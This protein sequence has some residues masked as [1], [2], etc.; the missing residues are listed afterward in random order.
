MKTFRHWLEGRTYRDQG[1][2]VVYHLNSENEWKNVLKKQELGL[3]VAPSLGV[4]MGWWNY[5]AGS[6]D[7]VY[8]LHK[9]E[10]PRWLYEKHMA[11][12]R[13]SPDWLGNKPNVNEFVLPPEEWKFLKPLSVRS[14]SR[15]D[16]IRMGNSYERRKAEISKQNQHLVSFTKKQGK[17]KGSS[18]VT[19]IKPSQSAIV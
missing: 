10:I 6:G 5:V 4:D 11:I 2:K 13:Q 15:S 8:Y 19:P 18:Y 9:I 7:M 17:E 12:G 3:W 14:Y 16:T 1:T